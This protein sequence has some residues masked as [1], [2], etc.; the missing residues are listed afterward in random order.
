MSE[1]IKEN[2]KVSG[3][4]CAA[5]AVSLESYLKPL[6]GVQ[7]VSVNYADNSVAIEFDQLVVSVKTLQQKAKEIGYNIIVSEAGGDSQSF[8]VIEKQRINLLKSKLIFST[9]FSLPVFLIAMFFM[10]KL[11]YENWIMMTLSIPVLFWGGSEFFVIAWKKLKHFSANM[12]TL[13]ALSTG[14]AFTFSVFNTFFPHYLMTDSKMPHVY[15]ESAVIII[16][17]ILLGR[18][19]EERA[20]LKTS[21]AIR[22]LMGLNPKE[23]TAIRKGEEMIIS[24][25]HIVHGEL[26]V[27]KPGDK[28]AVDGKV[29]RGES[30]IDESMI[31]GEPI[32][33]FKTKGDLVFSGTMNQRGALR[34]IA[35]KV[36]S[37]TLLSQIIKLV[38]QAQ[39]SKP[40]IQKLADKIAGVFVP[41]VIGIAIITFVIWYAFGPAP[42]TTYAILTLVTVLIIACPCALGLATPTAIMVG[43]GKGAEQGILIKDA[44]SLETA[45]KVD[46][47]VLDKTGTITEGKPK[48]TDIV[49]AGGVRYE[50]LE[51][52]LLAME[53]QSEHPIA[54]A[55]VSHLKTNNLT[56]THIDAFENFPGLG[57]KGEIGGIV[58]RAGNE[59]FMSANRIHIPENI[60]RSVSAMTADAKTVVYFSAGNTI[61]A[62]IAVADR[63]KE[64]AIS[65]LRQI[66][67]MGIEVHILTGD[68]EQTAKVI[69]KKTGV[70]H[71][72]SN[73]MPAGKGNFVKQLQEEGRIVAMAGDGINDSHALAQAD[74]GIAMGSGTDIAMESAGITLMHSDLK[75]IAKAIMLSK[76]TMRTVRQNLFWAFIY[77]IVAIPVAAGVLY[78]A[79]GFLLNP[80][81]AGAA[82]SM[83]SIS[84]VTNSLRLK[85]RSIDFDR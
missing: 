19:L 84:V 39:A 21:S 34:I 11:P 14:T 24:V 46:T 41:I 82:M 16:T 35:T 81:I 3:M 53:S 70:E 57:A 51:N 77:N 33:V 45:F 58:Y 72:R 15:Y 29:M 69:A 1:V 18:Y 55:I 54:E 49:W 62:V 10:G 59:K 48:V 23:V 8:E 25:D 80:M 64:N 17:L 42:S 85:K 43:I 12:D 26:I 61:E 36:G 13:V 31:S 76:A 60:S 67:E 52:I 71:Y 65:A 75:Q 4:T 44:Q 74:V 22:Q 30:Y 27:V 73:V 32:P 20:K 50:Q 6:E 40:A 37:E 5:C 28:I 7:Q 56:T 66:Q 9:F 68:N 38:E 47:L 63:L 79:F 78:P 83:S 2:Y